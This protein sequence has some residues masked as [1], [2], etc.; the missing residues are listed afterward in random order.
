VKALR[1]LSLSDGLALLCAACLIWGAASVA[2]ALGWL[3]ASVVFGVLAVEVGK[4]EVHAQRDHLAITQE[5]RRYG[6]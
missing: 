6:A 4:Q 3:A 5:G 2:P 1:A